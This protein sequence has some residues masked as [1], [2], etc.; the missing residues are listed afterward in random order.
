MCHE[1]CYK[2]TCGCEKRKIDPSV[3]LCLW[4][5]AKGI[6]CPEF[7]HEARSTNQR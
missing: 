6:E 1:P 2:F 3:S 7:Q 4:V 5:V